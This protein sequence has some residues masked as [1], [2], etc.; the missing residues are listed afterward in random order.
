MNFDQEDK[1]IVLWQVKKREISSRDN[2]PDEYEA[3]FGQFK[4]P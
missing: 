2:V 3:Q 4:I 1:Y